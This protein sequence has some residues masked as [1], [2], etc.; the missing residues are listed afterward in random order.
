METG[1]GYEPVLEE[2]SLAGAALCERLDEAFALEGDRRGAAG[3]EL[4]TRYSNGPE[5]GC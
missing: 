3:S 2:T 1:L 5:R 4:R